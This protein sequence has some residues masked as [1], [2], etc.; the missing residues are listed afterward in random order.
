MSTD[1]LDH[2][3]VPRSLPIVPHYPVSPRDE[4]LYH[5]R[6]LCQNTMQPFDGV[7]HCET[8]TSHVAWILWPVHSILHTRLR[9]SLSSNMGVAVR[10]MSLPVTCLILCQGVSCICCWAKLNTFYNLYTLRRSLKM[11]RGPAPADPK[12]PG[13]PLP[14]PPSDDGRSVRD[15]QPAHR[16]RHKERCNSLY[17]QESG[18]NERYAHYREAP[19]HDQIR[20]RFYKLINEHGTQPVLGEFGPS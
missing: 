8:L 12:D 2:I 15:S 14:G 11:A 13:L 4:R 6:R 18:L 9:D 17:Q 7:Y 19:T 16:Q 1:N 5:R 10:Y 20:I 3:V